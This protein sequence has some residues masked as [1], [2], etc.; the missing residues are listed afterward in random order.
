MFL[1]VA[2]VAAICLLLFFLAP[3]GKITIGEGN[4]PL[5]AGNAAHS[6]YL[7]FAPVAP[8]NERWDT[9]LEG[10]LIAPPAV[11]ADRIYAC[12][13]GGIVYCLELESGRPVWRYDVRGRITSMPGLCQDGVLLSTDDGRVVKVGPSGDLKWQAEAGGAVR[14]TA[15]PTKDRVYFG[16][17]DGYLYCVSL[18]DGLKLWSH[19]AEGPIDV[20]PCIYEDQVIGVSYEGD[21][22]ALDS[23]DGRL[24][25]TFRSHM[26]PAVFPCAD[27]G[28]V[29]LAT[30]FS[31]HCLDSQSGTILW[32]QETGP[33]I[34]ANLAIRGNQIVAAKGGNG[35]DST[36]ISMDSR[37]GDPLWSRSWGGSADW[38]WL[39]STNQDVYFAAPGYL[40]AVTVDGGTPSLDHQLE[41]I[42]PETFA[43]TRNLI[44]IAADNRKL[45][46][47]GQ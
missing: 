38:I 26:I 36:L 31:I 29:F 9:R 10:E 34:I 17:S 14:S 40:L 44:L 11:S 23:K 22:F 13:E 32:E 27:N 18:K 47:F 39:I 24:N 42:L 30:E 15:I 43:A 20:S 12:C 46:C 16:S 3:K 19:A 1:S 8:L 2:L 41:G 4:W 7:P 28:K 33:N 6:A 45:Y 37:T 5:P 21:L 35:Q 25:W